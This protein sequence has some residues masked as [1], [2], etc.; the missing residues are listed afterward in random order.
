LVATTALVTAAASQEPEAGQRPN[1]LLIIS[2]DIGTD[3]TS[4]MYPGLI[5][6]LVEQYGPSGHAH[7]DYAQIDGRP[8]STPT[9][10]A[11]ARDGM[12][13]AHAWM[14]P[15]CSPSRASVLTGLFA[16]KT[17]VLDYTHWLSQTHHSFVQDLKDDGGYSTAVF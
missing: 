4:N 7:P 9:L 2:D 1:I 11:L 3:V 17:G 13:L 10:D 8:A 5:D 16:A 6:S 12:S 15:F 14:Q